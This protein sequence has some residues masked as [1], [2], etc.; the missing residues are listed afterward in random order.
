MFKK[1][2]ESFLVPIAA[3]GGWLAAHAL[4]RYTKTV[5]ERRCGRIISSSP[6]MVAFAPESRFSIFAAA[7]AAEPFSL[8]VAPQWSALARDFV[9]ED[10]LSVRTASRGREAQDAR[11]GIISGRNGG[12]AVARR[13]EGEDFQGRR[14]R[15]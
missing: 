4:A 7:A 6:V 12:D 14:I 3:R 5:D 9:A 2:P 11:G 10:A 1:A 8:M 15:R 13:V